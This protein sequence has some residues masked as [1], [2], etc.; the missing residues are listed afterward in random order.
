[1]K[2]FYIVLGVVAVAGV[3]VVGLALR[4]GGGTPVSE[5]VDLGEIGNDALLELAQGAVYGNPDAPITIMEFG[6]YQCGGCA[7]F[8]LSVKPLVDMTYIEKGQAKLVFHDFPLLARHQHAFLAARAARC[9]GDQ[10]RY[11]E[12]HDEI[13]R[14]QRDWSVMQSTA[15]H[16]KD[17]ADDLGLDTRAFDACLDSDAHADL[18][19]AN[20]TL[21]MR[22]GVDLTPTVFVHDGQN[23]R[24]LAGADFAAIQAAIEALQSGNQ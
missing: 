20:L 11:F 9:A 21:G 1:M 23:S 2:R 6:D 10:D 19:T 8:G 7:Y 24:R 4:G 13:F 17:L 12:Y 14:T 3:V 22:L 15:G 5:P 16:F 18:V